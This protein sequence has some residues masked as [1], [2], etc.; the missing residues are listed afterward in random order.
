MEQG[1]FFEMMANDGIRE[2][3]WQGMACLENWGLNSEWPDN[4][5]SDVAFGYI[6]QVGA[7]C[8]ESG[9]LSGKQLATFLPKLLPLG[10]FASIEA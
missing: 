10:A 9:E 1:T 7:A 8:K 4:L 3:Y 2:L 6:V 5:Y